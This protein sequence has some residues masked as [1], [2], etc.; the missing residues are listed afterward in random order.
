MIHPSHSAILVPG[1]AP[2]P[3]LA[4]AQ[5]TATWDILSL[6]QIAVTVHHERM[7]RRKANMPESP[8]LLGEREQDEDE[9]ISHDVLSL[10]G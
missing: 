2:H 10:L 3:F 4:T 8:L 6:A 9:A 1:N 5:T 7:F